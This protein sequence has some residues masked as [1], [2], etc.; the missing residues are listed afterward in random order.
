MLFLSFQREYGNDILNYE[1]KDSNRSKIKYLLAY[2]YYIALQFTV[3]L[4]SDF[5]QYKKLRNYF[6]GGF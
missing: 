3:A 6:L 2:R 1:L 5:L 4:R